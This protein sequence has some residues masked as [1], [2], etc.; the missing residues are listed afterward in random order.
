MKKYFIQQ[1]ILF[2]DDC[3]L[4]KLVQKGTR[5]SQCLDFQTYLNDSLTR[6]KFIKFATEDNNFNGKLFF[7]QFSYF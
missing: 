2:L 5:K 7:I 3:S 4:Q 1:F 6:Y